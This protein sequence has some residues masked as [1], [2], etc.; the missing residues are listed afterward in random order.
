[1]YPGIRSNIVDME[2]AAL[3]KLGQF[4]LVVFFGL[5][6]YLEALVPRDIR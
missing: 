6:Y 1:M 4:D 5:V 2:D 3:Q